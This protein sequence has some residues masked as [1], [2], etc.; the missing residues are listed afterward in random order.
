MLDKVR[1]WYRSTFGHALVSAVLLW[2]AF[3]PADLWPLAW[4]APAWWVLLVR[5]GEL[6]GR[7]PYLKIWV[8]GFLFWLGALHWMRLPHWMTGFGWVALSFYLAFYVLVFVGLSRVAVHRLRV[9]VILAA[10]VVWTGLELVRAHLL[11]GFTM[12][13]LGHTQ[14]RWIEL[15]QLSDLAGAY[16]VGFLVMLV[17]ACLARMVPSDGKPWTWWPL[18]PAAGVLCAAL[19]YGH[20]RVSREPGEPQARIALI[21][22]SIDVVLNPAPGTHDRMHNQYRELSE[23]AVAQ[24]GDLDLI[25]WPETVFGRSLR[26]YAPGLPV[27]DDW[28]RSDAE[29]RLAVRRDTAESRKPMRDLANELGTPLLVGVTTQYFDLDQQ[30][31]RFNSAAFVP[32]GEGP[33]RPYHKMHLVVFGEYVPFADRLAW[34]VRLTPLSSLGSGASAGTQPAA[35]QLDGLR[36]S[37]NI[38]YESVIPHL[39]RHQVNAL[40]RRG[41]EPDV[42]VNLTND[43][44]FWGSSELDLHLVCGVF[45]AVECRKPLLIAANTGFSAWIDADGRILARGPRRATG[46]VLAEVAPDPRGSWYLEHGDWPA[47]VCLLACLVFA[48]VGTWGWFSKRPQTGRAKAEPKNGKRGKKRER[49]PTRKK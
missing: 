7:R 34:L 14:Y 1:D 13:S 40:A 19:V 15:I 4:V 11:T 24:Y 21:Q 31:K 48:A 8:A 35:F 9:P 43:G 12:A 26:D 49:R 6:S 42:L 18:L 16:G 39:I 33:I 46:V 3:P 5:R 47:G 10:P 44:W 27:P 45:R 2:A 20:L 32:L 23:K 22:G 30:W 38:C 29:F 36:L 28:E 41:Q 37:P 17:A 25:I